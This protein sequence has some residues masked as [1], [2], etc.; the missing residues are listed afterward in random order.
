MGS[1]TKKLL[2]FVLVF[3]VIAGVA[4][5]LHFLPA[6][7]IKQLDAARRGIAEAQKSY[8]GKYSAKLFNEAVVSY[9]SA[10]YLWSKENKRVFFRR[11]YDK[12]TVLA[13]KSLQKSK[14]A[15]ERSISNIAGFKSRLRKRIE[16]VDKLLVVYDQNF[17]DLPVGDYLKKKEAR[18]RMLFTEGKLAFDKKDYLGSAPKIDKAS[19]DIEMVYSLAKNRMVEY[20]NKHD[21]WV[22]MADKAIAESRQSNGTAIVVDKFAGKC[23]LY[24]AGKLRFTWD[25]ELGKNWIGAKKMKGDKATPEGTYRIVDKKGGRET[26]YYKALLINYPNEEDRERFSLAKKKGEIPKSAG[27]GNNIEIHGGGGKGV[28]WTDGC[29]ALANNDMD[30]IYREVQVGTPVTIVGSLKPFKEVFKLD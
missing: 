4:I 19:A 29:V 8:S 6:P 26:G 28:H 2:W 1:R 17:N 3:S 10:M 27:I 22:R 20:F 12:I 15:K 14:L 18:A 25:A 16:E 9:D 7:P 30:K 21:A 23:Y 5:W 11:N 13:I 24:E